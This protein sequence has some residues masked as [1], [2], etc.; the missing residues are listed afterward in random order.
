VILLWDRFPT[1]KGGGRGVDSG[2][3]AS[4]TERAGERPRDQVVH[5]VFLAVDTGE[6]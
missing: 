3:C 1:F 2:R 6:K 4:A 5:H